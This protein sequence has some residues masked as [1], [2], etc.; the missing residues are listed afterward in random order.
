MLNKT[1]YSISTEL[2]PLALKD[3]PNFDFKIPLNQPIGRFFYDPWQIKDEY[4]NTV[5][6]EILNSLPFNVGEARIILLKAGQCYGS[7]AD[8]DNRYHLNL[9]GNNS[10]LIDL[11]NKI[12]HSLI[13]D[14][15][16]YY[17]D[18]GR[19]HTAANF[20]N[21]ER[22]QL[23]VRELLKESNLLNPIFIRITSKIKDIEETRF[24]FDNNIS[25]WL[26]K[27][28]QQNCLCNFSS[29]GNDIKFSIEDEY[30]DELKSIIPKEFII[31]YD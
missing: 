6:N 24:I 19:R 4:S 1:Q 15:S 30:L 27:K 25:P 28:N 3:L 12:M 20:G 9:S 26:N 7:H 18:A 16:W 8:I 22:Y 5:W 29:D 14:G 13:N 31:H 17:M 10:F 21:R 2:I 11:E 23:V